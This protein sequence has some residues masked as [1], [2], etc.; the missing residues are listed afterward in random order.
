[1]STLS[2]QWTEKIDAWRSSGLNMAAWCR[3]NAIGYHRFLYWR[4]RLEGQPPK[5]SGRFVE[6]TLGQ[7][8]SSL[9]LECHGIYLHVERGFDPGLLT[10]ILAVLKKV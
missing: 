6:L 10:E 9:R 5:P 7:G 8:H 2:H 3:Q 4:N 1:M